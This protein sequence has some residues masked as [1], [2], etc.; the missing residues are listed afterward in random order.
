MTNWNISFGSLSG[1]EVPTRI[2]PNVPILVSTLDLS[3][4]IRRLAAF[5]S[6]TTAVSDAGYLLKLNAFILINESV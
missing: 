2:S 4:L 6:S 5:M 1:H 3:A